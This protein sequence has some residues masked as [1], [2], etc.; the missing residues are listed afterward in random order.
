MIRPLNCVAM[1]GV[2]LALSA[3]GCAN[4]GGMTRIG[5][6]SWSGMGIELSLPA[7][8]WA[9]DSLSSRRVA[10]FRKTH[11]EAHVIIMQ[12][13]SCDDDCPGTALRRLFAHF[14]KKTELARWR[15]PLQGGPQAQFAEMLV[16]AE[17]RYLHVYACAFRHADRVYDVVA[18]GMDRDDFNRLADGFRMM[19]R[20]SSVR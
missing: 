20:N 16:K 4:R 19:E 17:D 5:P 8:D 6:A 10:V 18:W 12:L 13:A 1:I 3:G 7:G 11:S 9:K 14:K 15:R 2:C